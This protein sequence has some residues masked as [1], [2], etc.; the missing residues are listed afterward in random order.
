[1]LNLPINILCTCGKELQA[2]VY[3]LVRGIHIEVKPCTDCSEKKGLEGYRIGYDEGS[4][5]AFNGIA[6]ADQT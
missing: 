1:M 4:S 3:S 6:T 5:A 2:E